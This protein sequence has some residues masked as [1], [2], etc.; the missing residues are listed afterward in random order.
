MTKKDEFTYDVRITDRH[1]KE[2]TIT[3]K[4]FD[5]Y[6]AGLP[7]V[8]DKGEPLVF[9][10]EIEEASAEEASAEEQEEAQEDEAV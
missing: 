4:E 7:D 9:D 5:K 10:D 6:I 8:E 2:G 1:L 3:K